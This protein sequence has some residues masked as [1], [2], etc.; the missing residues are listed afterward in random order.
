[1]DSFFGSIANSAKERIVHQN[2]MN[3]EPATVYFTKDISADSIVRMYKKLMEGKTFYGQTG[4]KL[5]DRKSV[6]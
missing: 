3:R 5:Q 2:R 6:V 4:I 1:M